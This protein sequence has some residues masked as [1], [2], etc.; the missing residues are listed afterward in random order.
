MSRLYQD[1]VRGF[2]RTE[3]RRIVNEEGETVIL[4]GWGAGNWMNPEG[5]MVGGTSPSPGA[6]IQPK[7]LDR[8]RSMDALIRELCGT[9]Y[10][11]CFWP[12]WYR[13]Q[14]G[15]KD[16]QA[17]AEL[18]YNSVRLPLNSAAFL[19]EEPGIQWNEDSFAMLDEVL[20]W[21]EKYRIYAILDLHAAP[22]GQSCG[23]CDNGVDNVPHLF[24]DEENGE[25]AML[26]WEELAGRYRERWIVG[27]YDLLNEPIND[28]SQ[29]PAYEE[30]LKEFYDEVIARIRKI[31]QKHLLTVE[32]TVW[33]THPGIFDHDYDPVCKNWCIHIHN[34][35]YIPETQELSAMMERSLALNVP[36]WMGEGGAGEKEN[37]VFLQI[38]EQENIGYSLWCWKTVVGGADG[39]MAPDMAPAAHGLPA[40][41][42][43]VFD[44][45]D[46]G[47]PKPGYEKS[48]RIFDEYL[49]LLD[50]DRC[51]HPETRHEY[52]LRKPGVSIPG[53]GYDHGEF[54]TAFHGN[55]SYGNAFQ[56]RE[57]DRMKL[58]LREGAK[59]PGPKTLWGF[60]GYGLNP[61]SALENLALALRKG[62]FVHYTVRDVRESCRVSLR[63]GALS[64][65]IL[66]VSCGGTESR[67]EITPAETVQELPA[68]TLP[69]GEEYAVRVEALEG[70]IYLE[71]VKF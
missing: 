22:G 9:E 35:R 49:E 18:G 11:R 36:I 10:A 28:P 1:M 6:Y 12:R 42:N 15:E 30:K 55:W 64:Q 54:G 14:L 63:L 71:E 70:E 27:A 7:K 38:L 69:Q 34:Y 47:G 44:Y 26:L 3:G 5:F 67:L 24:I 57:A 52:I 61:P 62:E 53:A 51:S 31:D 65:G 66:L 2:L 60:Y 20:D 50:Y 43:L 16:I 41:W 29:I 23:A 59:A 17:M 37:A 32:G 33:S 4:R 25:R 21:C 48:K 68:L 39:V 13:K 45:A 8:A 56:Y 58:V 40:D 46:H 19:L